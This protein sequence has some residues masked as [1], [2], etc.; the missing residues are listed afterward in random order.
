MFIILEM[1]YRMIAKLRESFEDLS[2]VPATVLSVDLEPPL[3]M[4][5]NR[6][7]PS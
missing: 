2:I 6:R 3:P 1:R 4:F 7:Q 5:E